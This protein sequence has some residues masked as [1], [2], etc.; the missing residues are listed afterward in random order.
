MRNYI[1]VITNMATL[2]YLAIHLLST[3]RKWFNRNLTTHSFVRYEYQQNLE[4]YVFIQEKNPSNDTQ[5]EI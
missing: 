1:K 5:L 3:N 2:D 4:H